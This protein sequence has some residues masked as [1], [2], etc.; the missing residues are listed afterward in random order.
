[1]AEKSFRIEEEREGHVLL[2]DSQQTN[3]NGRL[4]TRRDESFKK[5]D[6]L[7]RRWEFL[8]VQRRGKKLATK[9]LVILY[10]KNKHGRTRLG[11]AVSKKVGNSVRRN[12]LKRFIKEAFRRNRQ[13]FPMNFDVVVI[14]KKEAHK[15][16]Y[17][18][19]LGELSRIRKAR[20]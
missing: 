2:S 19:L 7:L 15:L 16:T 6:R 11:V 12:K 9:N 3:S 4:P 5:R 17:R 1:M 18:E 13:V 10:I 14:P 20:P 8:R